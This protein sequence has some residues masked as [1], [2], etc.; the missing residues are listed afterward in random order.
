MNFSARPDAQVS[1]MTLNYIVSNMPNTSFVG[2]AWLQN[3]V[4]NQDWDFPQPPGQSP[5][6]VSLTFP[7]GIFGTQGIVPTVQ[8]P[9]NLRVT[10]SCFV[11]DDYSNVRNFQ[12]Q[13]TG[14]I[15]I[16][17]TFVGPPPGTIHPE[18]GIV[19]GISP[20]QF[21]EGPALYQGI[22]IDCS[23]SDDLGCTMA[24]RM[25]YETCHF[26]GDYDPIAHPQIERYVSVTSL[27]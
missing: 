21:P 20:C 4:F 15:G 8:V 18:R 12:T 17:N 14:G 10:F 3:C 1:G 5:R 9:L 16:Q 7:P 2:D 25:P 26:F 13:T 19:A 11:G 27:Q 22:S 24:T 6:T 23:V